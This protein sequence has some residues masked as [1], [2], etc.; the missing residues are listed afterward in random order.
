VNERLASTRAVASLDIRLDFR[1]I[2]DVG[3]RTLVDGVSGPLQS[4][5]PDAAALASKDQRQHS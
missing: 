4:R 2:C 3:T 5:E 1:P